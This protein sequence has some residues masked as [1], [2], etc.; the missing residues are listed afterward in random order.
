MG[1]KIK[2]QLNG[3]KNVRNQEPGAEVDAE[4]GKR[5]IKGK[6]VIFDISWF[7]PIILHVIL[8]KN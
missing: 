2:L 6:I 4:D 8:S 3:G 1:W 5:G 7:L